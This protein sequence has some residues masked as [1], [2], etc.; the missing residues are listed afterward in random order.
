MAGPAPDGVAS[1][2]A[3]D[4]SRRLNAL[5][6]FFVPKAGADPSQSFAEFAPNGRCDE[7]RTFG[8]GTSVCC[9]A[10]AISDLRTAISLR[11]MWAWPW[12][13]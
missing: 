11:R 9:S 6:F 13:D 8:S 2:R 12:V 3:R 10:F 7:E 5:P 4:D 1:L